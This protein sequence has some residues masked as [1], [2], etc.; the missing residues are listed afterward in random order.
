MENNEYSFYGKD[1]VYVTLI[2]L[3][4]VQSNYIDVE[5]KESFTLKQLTKKKIENLK[6]TK[7][8]IFND[9]S[10]NAP[11]EGINSRIQVLKLLNKVY[12]TE[13]F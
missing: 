12:N 2:D 10:E 5:G 7:Y 9:D 6:T 3:L 1:Y 11:G 13:D 8:N 4:N